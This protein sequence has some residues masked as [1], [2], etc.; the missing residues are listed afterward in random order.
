M[1]REDD[2]SISGDIILYRRIPPWR[3]NVTW[4]ENVPR[5]SSRNFKDGNL[6]LSVSIAAE[7][8][9]DEMLAGHDGFGLIQLT[10]QQVRDI[11]GPS[12]K[13]CRCTEEP[14]MGHVLICGK[15]RSA[16]NKLQ[17]A[18]KWVDGRWPARNP[19][20]PVG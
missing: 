14:A 10:A 19:P 7:T 3:D 20:E 5:F 13:L 16:A 18:A 4:E 2:P 8:T 12:V 9:P 11:C 17:R 1:E 15:I 6:E